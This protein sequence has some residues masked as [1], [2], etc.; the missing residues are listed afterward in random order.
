[1]DIKIFVMV[2]ICVTIAMFNNIPEFKETVIEGYNSIMMQ[3]DPNLVVNPPRCTLPMNAHQKPNPTAYSENDGHV[4]NHYSAKKDYYKS[5]RNIKP[6]DNSDIRDC[7]YEKLSDPF[8][9]RDYTLDEKNF[10]SAHSKL[11]GPQNPKTLVPP[12]IT[13]P[14]YSM[15]WRDNSMQVPNMINGSTNENL[16]KAGYLSKED[17]PYWKD[18]DRVKDVE[19]K[20]DESGNVIEHYNIDNPIKNTYQK[21]DWS[22]EQNLANGY[23]ADQY[24]ENNYP[25]NSPQGNCGKNREFADYNKR[26]F[27]QIVQPG[28]YYK[29]DVIEPVNSNIGISFQQQ[30]L[31]RTIQEVENGILIEDH[32]PDFVPELPTVVHEVTP[33][34][35]NIYDPRFTGYGDNSRFYNDEVTG[36]IR[37]AYDDINNKRMPNYVVRSKIDTHNFADT[38]GTAEEGRSLSETRKLAEEAFLQDSLDHRNDEMVKLSRKANSVWWQRKQHPIRTF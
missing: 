18:Q 37:Y 32:N 4:K 25:A 5:T 38:Y 23:S 21:K 2:L 36:Q 11:Y 1:M 10:T 33:K 6:Q 19:L 3:C 35:D 26:L 34:E 17:I 13:R 22:D 27:T 29:E 20:Y 31:P 12:M 7:V 16:G 15:D 9:I 14:L 30:F 8:K 24:R 28:V